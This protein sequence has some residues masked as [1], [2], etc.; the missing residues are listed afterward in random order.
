[1]RPSGETGGVKGSGLIKRAAPI[2]VWIGAGALIGGVQLLPTLEAL[3]DSSRQ[4]AD[5]AFV[6]WGS[7]HP[8]NLV[9]LVAPYL[10]K[11]RVVGQNTHELG[12]YTGAVTVLL[13]AW[14]IANRPA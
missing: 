5:G 13:A 8:L 12:L 9:Q 11:T 7:L 1:M 2:V 10:F 14:G 6:G 3:G 4:A